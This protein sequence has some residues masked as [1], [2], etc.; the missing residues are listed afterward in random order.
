MQDVFIGRQPI[1]DRQLAVHAYELLFRH[2]ATNAAEFLNGDEAT[3]RVILT[4][5]TEIGLENIVG[6]QPAF[7]NL[8]RGF[9]LGRYPLPGLGGRLVLEVLEDIEVDQELVDGVARLA[10][11]GFRIALDDFIYRPHLAPL[12]ALADIVKIDLRALG[13]E[14]VVRHVEVLRR[15][16]RVQLVAEKV[17]TQEEFDFCRDLGFDYFQG[18]FLCRPNVVQGRATPPNRLAALR[19]LAELQKPQIDF[20]E[21]EQLIVQDVALTYRVLRYINSAFFGL[22]QKVESVHRAVVLLGIDA[23]RTLAS[24]I[25]LSRIDDKPH[26]LLTT[27]LLRAKMCELLSERDAESAFTVGL[28]SMLDAMMDRP[29]EELLERLP[30]SDAVVTALLHRKGPLGRVLAAVVRYERG[31]FEALEAPAARGGPDLAG[32]Y[33]QAVEYA[34]G[35]AGN[36][37]RPATSPA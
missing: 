12:V 23:L 5:F 21:L 14:E 17:E 19:L 13:R 10:A 27:A 28:F 33:L 34:D 11:Q 6:A 24:L 16:H 8:T 7:I 29:L 36:L 15:E 3:S 18:Y 26:E 25:V 22:R 4:T 20:P 1:Y 30:L 35:V 9:I 31:E 2:N 32:A 37:L